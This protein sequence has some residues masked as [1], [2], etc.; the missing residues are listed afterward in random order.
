MQDNFAAARGCDGERSDC[1][2]ARRSRIAPRW[3]D[4]GVA[5]H[6]M[7]A[8]LYNNAALLLCGARL[9]FH[10]ASPQVCAVRLWSNNVPWWDNV[11]AKGISCRLLPKAGISGRK[12]KRISAM[13]PLRTQP[14]NP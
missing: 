13:V 3:S 5:R 7:A 6:C 8:L 11:A 10:D 9:L 1:F 12:T 4:G 14:E 2:A